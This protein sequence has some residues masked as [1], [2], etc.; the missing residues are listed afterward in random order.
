M[1]LIF[2]AILFVL[3]LV[4][5][6]V[7]SF[8]EL[9]MQRDASPLPIKN[10]Y[11]RDPRYFAHSFR[12]IINENLGSRT[13]GRYELQL[14]RREV[15]EVVDTAPACTNNEAYPYICYCASDLNI[16]SEAAFLKE[17]YVRGDADFGA[18]NSLRALACDGNIILRHDSTVLRWID[19]EGSL[20]VGR[21]CN[22]G[23]SASCGTEMSLGSGCSFKRLYAFPVVAG[24]REG[25]KD[26]VMVALEAD[27]GP[28]CEPYDPAQ[29]GDA[30][31]AMANIL[32][33]SRKATVI[34]RV[35]LDIGDYSYI[36][37]HVK[38]YGDLTLGKY[39]IVCGN[40]FVEGVLRVGEGCHIH[41]TV[42][43]NGWIEIGVGAVVGD[44]G[45]I[46]SVVARKGI[47]LMS[48]AMVFGLV[49][50]EGE[51]RVA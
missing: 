10:D 37:G 38:S 45:A 17:I 2:C 4:L 46:K 18:R 39:V 22:L 50:T 36:A 14:S 40:V 47:R 11:V 19:A 41:G 27:E 6:F 8:A 32:P 31:L 29:L 5:P 34:T 12:R 21:D 20:R 25:L 9:A 35:S 15:V 13:A 44:S 1:I 28:I 43:S 48:G 26:A 3:V 16:E 24:G 7:P 49:S 23:V 42:F 30:E 51:G 33:Y